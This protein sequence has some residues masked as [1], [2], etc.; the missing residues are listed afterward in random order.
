M[1]SEW[2]LSKTQDS[3]YF[4]VIFRHIE[5]E[6]Y[7]NTKSEAEEW[8]R[9]FLERVENSVSL[10]IDY[11]FPKKENFYIVEKQGEKPEQRKSAI[12]LSGW[13][14]PII[15]ASIF[16]IASKLPLM[17]FLGILVA[18]GVI[19]ITKQKEV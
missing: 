8:I 18:I 15:V 17:A 12:K 9:D 10:K 16:V 19:Y 2:T 4:S 13:L 3:T 5:I 14:S 11:C 1:E 6:K 7:F